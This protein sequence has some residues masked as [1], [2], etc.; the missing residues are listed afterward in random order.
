MLSIF[1]PLSVSM[2]RL[3]VLRKV[4]TEAGCACSCRLSAARRAQDATG[5]FGRCSLP[6]ITCNDGLFCVGPKR[7]KQRKRNMDTGGY[8]GDQCWVCKPELTCSGEGKEV[9]CKSPSLLGMSARRRT[10][11]VRRRMGAW[12]RPEA[13]SVKTLM[14]EGE[15][16]GDAFWECEAGLICSWTGKYAVCVDETYWR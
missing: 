9:V 2:H 13:S 4:R 8:C 7:E 15:Y 14:G 11:C 3:S 5:V 6:I 1:S 10:Q 16:C 12:G